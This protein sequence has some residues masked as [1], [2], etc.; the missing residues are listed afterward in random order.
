MAEKIIN[1]TR[2]VKAL[3]DGELPPPPISLGDGSLTDY[4]TVVG[5]KLAEREMRRKLTRA[6]AA[7]LADMI[8][9]ERQYLARAEPTHLPVVNSGLD[10]ALTA[11]QRTRADGAV[12]EGNLV[13]LLAVGVPALLLF[14]QG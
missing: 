8:E 14:A 6:E 10:P 7:A 3:A 13:K 5:E 12:S 4:A 9:S 11:A 2:T 1:G